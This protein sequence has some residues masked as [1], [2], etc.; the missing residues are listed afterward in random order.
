MKPWIKAVLRTALYQIK[1][2]RVPVSAAINEAVKLVKK[3]GFGRLS[4]FANAVLRRISEVE[5]K[6]PEKEDHLVE[7]LSIKYSFPQWMIRFWLAHYS[8]DFVEKLLAAS[9]ISP[10]ITICANV[11]K[12]NSEKLQ[13]KLEKEG[14]KVLPG[15][16][17]DNAL[18]ITESSDLTKLESFQEGLFHV[19]D[20]ASI[21]AV[22]ILSPQ[23]GEKILDVCAAPGGKSLL[24]AEKMGNTGKIVSRDIYRH[25]LELIEES[26]KRLEID[27]IETELKD[28]LIEDDDELFDRVIVDAPCS[29]LGIIRKKP[30]IKY[31]RTGE[32]IDSLVKIQ[33]QIL[34]S[35][36]EKVKPGGVLVYSTCTICPKENEKNAMWF[37]ENFP[38]ILES[39]TFQ[40]E[41]K[42]FLQLFPH[43]DETD[44]FFI[45][46]FRRKES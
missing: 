41:K 17:T 22:D 21:L 7:Y 10:D 20:E 45:A 6:L 26:A 9:N 12:T 42:E 8:K 1:F 33:K 19:Q 29:G 34:A 36:A 40:G 31:N 2:M 37:Q 46:K 44:G 14:V 13:L 32:D 24:S 43:V 28:A 35:S 11:L 25:K 38:F 30:D 16:I 27:I 18:H 15:K 3:R 4:G 23:P 5:I 39:I